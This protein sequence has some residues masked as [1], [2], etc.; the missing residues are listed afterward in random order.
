MNNDVFEPLH[1]TWKEVAK[2]TSEFV[3]EFAGYYD[4]HSGNTTAVLYVIDKT[5]P[6][7]VAG[8][9]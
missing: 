2:T 3:N 9:N 6:N 5:T 8:S 7:A 1:K 4:L